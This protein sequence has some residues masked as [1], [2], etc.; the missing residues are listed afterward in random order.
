MIL[1]FIDCFITNIIIFFNN[2][3]SESIRTKLENKKILKI[4]R[5]LEKKV[6]RLDI[7]NEIVFRIFFLE[8]VVWNSDFRVL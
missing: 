4:F 8:I 6:F 1:N 3:V 2:L 7:R 5:I